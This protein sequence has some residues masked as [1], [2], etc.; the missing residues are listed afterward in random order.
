MRRRRFATQLARASAGMHGDMHQ[1][2]RAALRAF[3]RARPTSWSLTDCVAAR[4]ADV[5]S[6]RRTVVSLH[7]PRGYRIARAPNRVDGTRG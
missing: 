3:R 2:D 1:P 6:V 5:R 7:P 4:G